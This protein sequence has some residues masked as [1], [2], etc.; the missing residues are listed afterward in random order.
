MGITAVPHDGPPGKTR[1]R[2]QARRMLHAQA[3]QKGSRGRSKTLAEATDE[4][5]AAAPALLG[6]LFDLNGLPEIFLQSPP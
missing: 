4:V 6:H 3:Q 2:K 1:T 5:F